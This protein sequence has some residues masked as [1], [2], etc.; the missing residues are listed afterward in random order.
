MHVFSIFTPSLE[1]ALVDKRSARDARTTRAQTLETHTYVGA[2]A[3]RDARS[4]TPD[5]TAATIVVSADQHN[6][7]RRRWQHQLDLVIQSTAARDVRLP[8]IGRRGKRR[9]GARRGR[10][11]CASRRP[12]H[13]TSSPAAAQKRALSTKANIDFAAD[14]AEKR[15]HPPTGCCS[16]EFDKYDIVEQAGAEILCNASAAYPDDLQIIHLLRNP[17]D[18]TLSSCE[19]PKPS[20]RTVGEHAS[21]PT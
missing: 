6:R 21:W 5:I 15:F 19:R 10:V 11:Q 2:P 12:S 14:P 1:R 9:P 4:A 13:L 3:G 8:Q 18:L 20:Q 7:C 16:L 17:F